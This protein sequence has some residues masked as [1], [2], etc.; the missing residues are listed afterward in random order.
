M[1]GAVTGVGLVEAV[2]GRKPENA[3]TDNK[4]AFNWKLLIKVGQR[5]CAV[6]AGLAF[7]LNKKLCK[8]LS[9]W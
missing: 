3:H 7:C 5:C 6:P 9:C 1:V 4:H 8:F 2:S